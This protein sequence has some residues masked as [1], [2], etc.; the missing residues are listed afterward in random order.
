MIYVIIAAS[1]AFIGG[2]PT[3]LPVFN[4][5]IP[6]Y[7][8]YI[9]SL[10]PLITAYAITRYRLMDIEVIIRKGSIYSALTIIMSTLYFLIIYTSE[11]YFMRYTG[12]NPLWFTIPAIVVL[13][14][15]FQPL[16]DALQDLI[17]RTFFRSKY[18]ADLITKKFSEGVKK[19]MRLE[20]FARY[21]S[22]VASSTFDL[23]GSA[24]YIY[25]EAN[26]NY[27][28]HD[29][30]GT[31]K[32]LKGS[33]IN[34]D[35]CLISEMKAKGKVLSR[36][37]IAYRIGQSSDTDISRLK[38][39]A[40]DLTAMNFALCVPSISN[41]KDYRLLGFLAVD[42]KASGEPFSTEE[43]M[44]METLSNQTVT[45]IEN[46]LLYKEKLATVEKSFKLE[47]LAGLGS[48]T[49]GVA[50]ET[51]NALGY[52]VMFSELLPK[53]ADKQDFLENAAT[54]L[55]AEVERIKIILQGILDY[56]KPAESHPE[57]L[58]IK[59][60]VE[61]TIVLVRDQAKSRNIM[62]ERN[63][64][65]GLKIYADRNALKQVLLNLFMNSLDAMEG[66]GMLTVSA[67]QGAGT[68]E[69]RVKDTG[70]GMSPEVVKKVFDPFFTTKQQGTGLGLAIVKKIVEEN[71]GAISVNS[72][73]GEGT[74]FTISFALALTH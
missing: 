47:K 7:W 45:G 28:C 46:A 22:R 64:D 74:E 62:I 41:K 9:N 43:I 17:D 16:R 6:V 63:I 72:R 23:K 68:V 2:S 34:N 11:N 50:H 56:S 49:A 38:C 73:P 60:L 24:C 42:G 10:Y 55:P 61:E 33:L 37:E 30:L 21:I 35:R 25:D 4:I 67:L 18:E 52:V 48:A 15:L 36:E 53:Y 5:E 13:A 14:L 3:Y 58:N 20:D 59:N 26:G 12:Q 57:D 27:L 39:V 70:S 69:I 29:G 66:G 8:M 71:R 32:P 51:K 54:A 65:E 19:L 40:E 1:A 44:L 31:L